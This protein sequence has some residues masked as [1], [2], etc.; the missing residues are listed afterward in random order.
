MKQDDDYHHFR[1]RERTVSM[2]VPFC[3]LGQNIFFHFC[4][5]KITKIIRHTENF[6][7]FILGKY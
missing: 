3:S 1:L 6:T 2:V 7:N 4:I 5:K